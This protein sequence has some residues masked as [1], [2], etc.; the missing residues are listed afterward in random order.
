MQKNVHVVHSRGEL[1]ALLFA[2]RFYGLKV[3]I[4]H[5][6]PIPSPIALSVS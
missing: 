5:L 1:N 2:A 4:A 3:N 6:I